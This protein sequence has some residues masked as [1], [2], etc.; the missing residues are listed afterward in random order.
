LG[1]YRHTLATA[2]CE[3][4][5]VALMNKAIPDPVKGCWMALS[6]ACLPLCRSRRA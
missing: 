1:E 4:Q 2:A 3:L 6:I 5:R